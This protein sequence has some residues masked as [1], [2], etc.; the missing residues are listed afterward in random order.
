MIQDV[1]GD[2]NFFWKEIGRTD[3]GNWKAAIK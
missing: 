3:D 1:S 2:E